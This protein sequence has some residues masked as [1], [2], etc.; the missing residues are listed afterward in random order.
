MEGLSLS[1]VVQ[2]NWNLKLGLFHLEPT[3]VATTLCFLA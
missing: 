2:L 1:G 3:S